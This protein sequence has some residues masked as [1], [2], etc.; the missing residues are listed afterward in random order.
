MPR[1]SPFGAIARLVVR[2]N[3]GLKASSVPGLGDLQRVDERLRETPS[4]GA[5]NETFEDSR[6]GTLCD[7]GPEIL[8]SPELDGSLWGDLDHV[9]SVS[10]VECHPASFLKNVPARLG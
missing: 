1:Y 6:L 4:K 10:A 5:G 2:W 9:R 7:D 3:P 8:K